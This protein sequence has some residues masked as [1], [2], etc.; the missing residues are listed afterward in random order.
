MGFVL[1]NRKLVIKQSG[2]QKSY[3]NLKE[4]I[5]ITSFEQM[6][7]SISKLLEKETKSFEVQEIYKFEA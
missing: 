7:L 5:E 3:G 2:G 4:T 6:A 1:D